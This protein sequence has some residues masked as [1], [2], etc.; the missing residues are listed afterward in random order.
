MDIR[1]ATK[2]QTAST[3][4]VGGTA[5]EAIFLLIV[6]VVGYFYLIAP[7]YD[8]YAAGKDELATLEAKQNEVNEQ[9]AAFATLAQKLESSADALVAVDAALPLD[10]KPSR[11][12][13][14]V[15]N[16]LQ[17]SGIV[18]GSVSVDHNS[19]LVVAGATTKSETSA[20]RAIQPT[21]IVISA[22]STI[23]QLNQFLRGLE[24]SGR[25]FEVTDLSVGQAREGQIVFKVTAKA[26]AYLPSV[27]S[28]GQ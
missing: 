1:V 9:K 18:A 7:K 8:V 17:R 14:L 25:I 22:T 4:S 26:Y 21:S 15:E 23:D 13:V 16:I 5:F 12:Y 3:P 19:A 20:S 2:T 6:I 10:S 28:S 24:T 27:T 11:L